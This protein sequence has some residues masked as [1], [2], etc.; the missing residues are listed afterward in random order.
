MSRVLVP[1]ISRASQPQPHPR[2]GLVR[3]DIAGLVGMAERG[4][5]DQAVRLTSWD[6]YRRVFGGFQTFGYLPF[7]VRGFFENGG[8][9]CYVVRVARHSPDV[10]SDSMAGTAGGVWSAGAKDLGPVELAPVDPHDARKLKVVHP[11]LPSGTVVYFSGLDETVIVDGGTVTLEHPLS[12]D[13]R[14]ARWV[15][16]AAVDAQRAATQVTLS[17]PVAAG[18]G[19]LVT[20]FPPGLRQSLTVLSRQGRTIWLRGSL[21]STIPSG[22]PLIVNQ[23][24][25]HINASS[26]GSWGNRLRVQIFA[27]DND[28]PRVDVRVTLAPGAEGGMP[29][30]EFL[31]RLL[32]RDL[33]ELVEQNS[34]LIRMAFDSL[35]GDPPHI[36]EEAF[37]VALEGGLDDVDSLTAQDY[38]GDPAEPDHRR[39]YGLRLLEDQDDV[40]IVALPDAVY[41]RVEAPSLPDRPPDP[42]Q[43]APVVKPSLSGEPLPKVAYEPEQIYRG[44]LAHCDRMR[45]RVAVIDAPRDVRP[46][47]IESNLRPGE[48]LAK[49]GAVYHP[50]LTVPNPLADARLTLTVPASG[51]VAG[52][53]ARI[54]R[55]L[56]VHHP[57]A[58]G[59]LEFVS[60]VASAVDDA[61][62][63]DFNDAGID[64]IRGFPGRGIRVWGAR[65]LSHEPAWRYIHARRLLSYVEKSVETAMQWTVFETNDFALRRTLVHMLTEFLTGIWQRGGL[66]GTR[67]EQGFYVRCDET[68]NPQAVTDAGQI[69]CEVG[70]A[71]PA[72]MEFLVFEIRLGAGGVELQEV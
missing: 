3:T 21:R 30:R 2:L 40:A 13:D 31:R 48:R 9:E 66:Q 26:P 14:I 1:G 45:Y 34:N 56:G 20:F 52:L 55:T 59:A 51:H 38:L 37:D 67:P 69:V 47:W 33:P 10:T 19:D 46:D 28:P 72:P 70:V 60:G 44:L 43:C 68:N 17:R 57:P 6:E 58:N 4:P 50:W 22:T 12:V 24:R 25:V 42:C 5:L 15:E 53:Y 11:D 7:A 61:A 27:S 35:P 18:P 65:S 63:A 23:A 62:H 16:G 41:Q 39:W 8:V 49:W 36:G 29:Q 71:I 64:V 54:D 32:W